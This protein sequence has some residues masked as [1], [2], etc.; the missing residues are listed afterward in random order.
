MKNMMMKTKKILS[1]VISEFMV[2]FAAIMIP[3]SLIVV[4]EIFQLYYDEEVNFS[5]WILSAS[6]LIPIS[7]AMLFVVIL[8]M[9]EEEE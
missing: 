2:W 8:S 5:Q 7:M 4:S 3:I 6:M 1:E 9:S